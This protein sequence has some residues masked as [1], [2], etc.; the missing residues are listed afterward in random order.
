MEQCYNIRMLTIICGEDVIASR[1]YFNE[2]KE[3]YRKKGFEIKNVPSSQLDDLRTWMSHSQ[4]LFASQTVYVSENAVKAFKSKKNKKLLESIDDIARDSSVTWIDWEKI[5][6]REITGLKAATIKEL[7][8]SETIFMF[9]DNMYPGN[10]KLASRQLNTLADRQDEGFIFAMLCKHI[11]NLILAKHKLQIP[12][13]APWQA[14]KLAKQ[15]SYWKDGK[16]EAFYEGLARIDVSIKTSAN[17]HGL[18]KSLDI[19]FCYFL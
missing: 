6:A 19:L 15:A 5:T 12:G 18:G 10:L 8:P 4:G 11:R 17:I 3:S 1:D 16:L 7:K 14:G 9:L 13:V 2:M